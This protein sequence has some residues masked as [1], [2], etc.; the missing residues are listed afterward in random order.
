MIHKGSY[1]ETA[2]GLPLGESTYT[3]HEGCTDSP[4]MW[5][6]HSKDGY[7]AYCN[8]CGEKG[9]TGKG[10][11]K[12]S[13]ITREP[14]EGE[15]ER[16]EYNLELPDD[17]E[18]DPTKWPLE[19]K[20]WV[21]KADIRDPLIIQWGMAYSPSH[22]RVILPVYN[23]FRKLVL[24][25]GRG[26]HPDQTKYHTLRGVAKNKIIM[27]SWTCPNTYGVLGPGTWDRVV[28]VEDYLSAIKVGQVFPTVSLLGTTMSDFQ[29]LELAKFKEVVWWLDDDRGGVTATSKAMKATSLLTSCRRVRSDKDPK[30]LPLAEIKRII[31]E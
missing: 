15:H 12:I 10:I 25:Q 27:Q 13:D 11:R 16:Y 22:R 30:L 18:F 26:L 8:K 6:L 5:V 31:E 20:I 21:Y 29:L 4:K 1:L 23:E 2:K 14:E 17:C 9:F 7:L 24:W 3:P 19:A 28:V